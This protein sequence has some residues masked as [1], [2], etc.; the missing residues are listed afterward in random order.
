MKRFVLYAGN[1]SNNAY[2]SYLF[3]RKENVIEL[4]SN[5]LLLVYTSMRDV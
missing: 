1:Q 2:V 4:T 5:L 3:L